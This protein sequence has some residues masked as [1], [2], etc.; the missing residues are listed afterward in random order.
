[1]WDYMGP[2]ASLVDDVFLVHTYDQR[3][4]GRSSGD[5]PYT[6]AQFI[7][8]LDH[9]RGASG[10]ETWWVGGHSWGAELA[11]RYALAHPDRTD[12]MLY[13]A[14]TGIGHDYRAAQQ[15]EVRKRMG[16]KYSR[17]E[18]LLGRQDLTPTE[19]EELVVLQWL[20]DFVPG[21]DAEHQAADLWAG[22]SFNA[23]CYI[24]LGA[25]RTRNEAELAMQCAK[26]DIPVLILVGAEDS[27][28]IWATD[29]LAS[30]L[31]SV[32]RLIIEH[33]AHMP[34][35][36]QPAAVAEAVHNFIATR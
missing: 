30:S 31:P 22:H 23:K 14:G 34:W 16:E 8:D 10:H 25:D 4:C 17:W 2:M 33:A 5:G 32:Q 24:E 20:P 19:E 21:L 27:R 1:M 18:Y 29:S 13:I 9:L 36:D 26:L 11:L 15:A 6:V 3:G 28:P 35:L 12:G 7:A